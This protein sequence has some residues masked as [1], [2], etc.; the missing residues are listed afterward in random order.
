MK[1]TRLQRLQPLP[2]HD[3]LNH[4]FDSITCQDLPLPEV[5]ISLA[6]LIPL[7]LGHPEGTYRFQGFYGSWGTRF[8]NITLRY[9]LRIPV[10]VVE[11]VL[12]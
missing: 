12:D 5:V 8:V 1:P 10:M 4:P 7:L 2:V 9:D 3:L 6:G 11:E